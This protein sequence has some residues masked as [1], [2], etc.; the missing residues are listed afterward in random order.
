MR[1]GTETVARRP[2]RDAE[3]AQPTATGGRGTTLT[4]TGALIRLAVRRDRV[5][6]P[7]WVAVIAFE[8]V[9]TASAYDSLYPTAASRATL[10]PT[11]GHNASLLALYGPAFDLSSAGGFTAWRILGFAAAFAGLMS[12]L[13]VVRHTRGEEESG[14]LELI[15]SGVVGR[16]APLAAALAVTSLAN[17]VLGMLVAAGLAALA[18]PVAG[19]LATAAGLGLTGLVFTA[20]AGVTAQLTE[21]A[22]PATGLAAA[23]L[24]AAY[25]LRAVGDSSGHGVL[26]WLSWISPIGWAQQTRPYAGERW[27]VLVVPVVVAAVLGTAAVGL[28]GR[29]DFAGSLLRP[30]LGPA[31]APAQ[32]AS[33][34]GLAW[35][36]E[37]G[38]FAAWA[39]GSAL[40]A[41]AIGAVAY[42]VLDLFRGNAALE[43]M[44]QRM[45]GE[46]NLIDAFFATIMSL[47]A[48]VVTIHAVQLMLRLRAEE[49]GSH[50]EQVL[51]T[52]VSRRRFAVS[53][54]GPA[55]VGPLVL[56]ALTGVAAGV[57]YA[58]ISGN[59]GQVRRVLAS[60]VL[61]VP[62]MWVLVGAAMALIGLLPRFTTAAWALLAGFAVLGEIGPLLKLPTAV[63]KVSPYA[64]VPSLL[65]D[66]VTWTP[67]IVLLGVAAVLTGV[68]LATYDR[69]DIT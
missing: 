62:A 25:L 49:T 16:H 24:G 44:L 10:G 57:P 59:G 55:L 23:A 42:G 53:H 4:G 52:A 9:A 7:A 8:L 18:T 69:R 63:L 35:R 36:L 12:L 13:T 32:L 6:L 19:A 27:G 11:I 58:V 17:L 1:R 41:A 64:N 67:P 33:P 26:S 68:G 66:T 20:V 2:Q 3:V 22:R 47:M 15:R 61:F 43:Q 31:R 39:V 48:M 5:W 38:G 51:A 50:A 14:R 46:Q 34:I 54:L 40:F 21:N 65:A 56:M 30:R 45:G 29:R 28:E 60:A 37:R